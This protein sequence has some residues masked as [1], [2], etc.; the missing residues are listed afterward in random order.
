MPN[1]DQPT[2]HDLA[3]Q[4]INHA[5]TIQASPEWRAQGERALAIQRLARQLLLTEPLPLDQAGADNPAASP[6]AAIV[7]GYLHAA[8][9]QIRA[10]KT[11]LDQIPA[12]GLCSEQALALISVMLDLV[13]Q[14]VDRY[15][16]VSAAKK[17]LGHP[18]WTG[19]VLR[20]LNGDGALRNR[21]IEEVAA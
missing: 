14:T 9:D 18:A 17:A 19:G 5:I 2:I 1:T 13:N 20:P 16:R 12:E 4:I 8:A 10:A 7:D 21:T 11:Q 3:R 15:W 6:E